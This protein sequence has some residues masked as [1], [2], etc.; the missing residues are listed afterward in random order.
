MRTNSICPHLVHFVNCNSGKDAKMTDEKDWD[1]LSSKIKEV[2]NE[3]FGVGWQSSK[4]AGPRK[5][6]Y[7]T[8]HHWIT[9]H[10]RPRQPQNFEHFLEAYDLFGT[11][12]AK[13]LRALRAKALQAENQKIIER[14]E[15]ISRLLVQ[16]ASTS[17]IHPLEDKSTISDGESNNSN[18]WC[19]QQN[20]AVW[21][22][23]THINLKSSEYPVANF[24]TGEISSTLMSVETDELKDVSGKTLLHLQCHFGLDTLSWA[25]EGAKVTGVDF[26]PDAIYVAKF[27]ATQVGY[28]EAR[29]ECADVM[30]LS[31][32]IQNEQFDIVF[33]SYGVLPWLPDLKVWAET[34]SSLLK[35]GGVFYMVEFHPFTYVFYNKDD[36]K[37][38]YAHKSYFQK[39]AIFLQMKP[40]VSR[41]DNAVQERFDAYQWQH[42][43][44]DIITALIN[45]GL[46][47]EFLHEFPHTPWK[48][49][50][51]LVRDEDRWRRLPNPFPEIPLIFSIKAVKQ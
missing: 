21:S 45:A 22:A 46:R 23:L 28:P 19:L 35:P 34:V 12:I 15:N 10:S 48:H 18:E 37:G 49:F 44:G 9:G 40:Y 41:D 47:I 25:R 2:L 38:L 6:S 4:H 5:F 7:K 14:V 3:K 26:D 16:E 33:T 51:F 17:A 1:I 29:F 8:L 43:L 32:V 13:E 50:P 31:K 39:D 36:V 30:Q 11:D 27:L 24:A 20:R 42:T